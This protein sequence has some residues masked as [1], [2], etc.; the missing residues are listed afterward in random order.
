MKP[1]LFAFGLSA[2][3]ALSGGAAVRAADLNE[4]DLAAL[5]YFLSIDDQN[6][7]AAEIERLRIE[8][9]GADIEGTL[10]L[11]DQTAAQ[12]D[13]S[14]VW[15]KIE[16]KSYVEARAEIARLREAR[17]DWTPPADMMEILDSN[18]GQER[19]E[20]A[21]AARDREGVI[22]AL[23]AFPI[24]L[25]C[26]RI[27]NAWRLAELQVE[28]DL[29]ADALATY[30]GILQTCPQED[31][32]VATLQKS[33]EIADKPRLEE[34]LTVAR[35][36]NPALAERIAALET[37]LGAGE[38][39]VV[40]A[41][42][43]VAAAPAQRAASGGGGD[44]GGSRGSSALSRAQAAADRGDWGA[45][46]E[47]TTGAASMEALSQRGWCAY[48]HGRSREAVDAFRRVS[49]GGGGATARDATYG[50]ILAYAKLGQLEQA[51]SVAS[52]AKL[53]ADQ[54]RTV[55]QT[56][57][58]KLATQSFERKQYRQT[59]DYLDRLSRDTGSLDRGLAMLRGWALLKSGK[60]GSAREQFSR[61]HAAS[62]G[63]DSLQGLVESR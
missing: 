9:P 55:N 20:A 32:V 8:F 4:T 42:A 26:E 15:R 1:T 35:T 57:I 11:I 45:C 2:L 44:G 53:T 24:I 27:N 46:L 14:P 49:Q 61:V 58:S 19:F 13:T 47:A 25:N 54:R 29:K 56:V 31:Y 12:V 3:V 43:A 16:A 60:K 28:D 7:A 33:N 62:P 39:V 50:L 5:R 36:R 17:P 40:P 21:F 10:A 63:K 51:A 30:E 38:A 41:A 18:E 22:A 37:E 52:S 34:L 6:S 48:N 59:L 23:A